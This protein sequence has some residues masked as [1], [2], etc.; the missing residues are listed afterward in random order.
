MRVATDVGGTFTDLVCVDENGVRTVKSDTT[1]PNFEQGVL[2]CIEKSELNTKDFTYFAH[3]TT[4][5]INALLSRKGAKTALIT[6]RGFR[7]VLEIARGNRPD[8]FNIA[9]DKPAP[10]VPRHLRFEITERLDYQG[11][12]TTPAA[13]EEL[14]NIVARLQQEQVEA[15]AI[16]LLHGYVN[17]VHEQQIKTRLLELWPQAAVIA[18]HEVCREWR[19][20]ERTST[21]VLSAYVLPTANHYLSGLA[22]RLEEK[23]LRRSPYIMQSNGGVATVKG[24]LADPITLVESGPASGMLGAAA[25]G[26]VIGEENLIALDIG[27]TTAKCALIHE[28]KARITTEY[29]IEWDRENPGYPIRT[30]VVDLVE[31]GN[32]GGSIAW[33]DEGGSMHVGPQSA[34]ST[35]GPAAYGRGGDNATTTDA[36]LLLG[37]INPEL[38]LGGSQPPDWESVDSAFAKLAGQ[39]GGTSKDVARGVIRIANANMVN[40]LKLISLNRGHDPRDFSLIAFGGGGAMH[41]VSL[42]EDLQVKKVIIPINASV[43]SAWGMLMSDLRRDFLQTQVENLAEADA[44]TIDAKYDEI[45]TAAKV[46]CENEGI[47]REQMY[48]ERFADMRYLGQEHTIKVPVPA[49]RI[50]NDAL[51]VC[52][53]RFH[54]AH[55]REYAFKLDNA[56][57]LVNYHLVVFGKI[58]K[59]PLAEKPVTG[60]TIEAAHKGVRSVDYDDRGVRPVDIYDLS[61]LEP[62]MVFQGPAIVE[63]ANNAI[64]ITSNKRVSMDRYGNIHIEMEAQ[65]ND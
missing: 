14:D 42:A 18:S 25:I 30:P 61:R 65:A 8:L 64:V 63:D 28:G 50:D 17:P 34:G 60:R 24:T 19:E 53:Q 6:T 43:F 38:F 7:D 4:V 58:D 29:R 2:N 41:A 51:A 31:I 37:R 20:Y 45:A 40:A 49:G 9:F 5:V 59:Q 48:L 47:T 44:A 27:G 55:E 35:P 16:C 12:V 57:E 3:G 21:S 22:S 32:G 11:E 13:L 26:K 62:G 46:Q 36:N 1:P 54:E 33:I 15:V 39:L 56:V 52:I 23:G 10:F